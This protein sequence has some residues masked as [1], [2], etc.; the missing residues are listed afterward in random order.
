[1]YTGVVKKTVVLQVFHPKHKVLTSKNINHIMYSYLILL[2]ISCY[3]FAQCIYL[4]I[5]V[6]E[7]NI[8]MR[9]RLLGKCQQS[10]WSQS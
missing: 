4:S 1:M 5:L 6:W 8:V 3:I 2:F 9:L 10:L 7:K